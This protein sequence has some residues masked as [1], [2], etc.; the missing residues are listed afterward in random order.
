MNILK[1]LILAAAALSVAAFADAKDY[2]LTSPDGSIEMTVNTDGQMTIR[3]EHDGV[4]VLSPSPISIERMDGVTWGVNPRVQKAVKA[5]ADGIVK[6]QF[7]RAS[8]VKEKYNSLILKMRGGWSLELRAFDDGVAYRFVNNDKK[9]FEIRDEKADFRFP[10]DAETIVPYVANRKDGDF[11]GQYINSFENTYTVSH[12]S[13]LNQQHLSFLPLTV[14][15]GDDVK[16]CFT[17]VN[18]RDYPGMYLYNN[19]GSNHLV[20]HFAPYP[21]ETY[22][23]GHNNLQ[24]FVKDREEYI[25]KVSGPREFP[26]RAIVIGS[27]VELAASDMTYLLADGSK[28]EDTSW[29]RPGKV[30]WDWWNAWNIAGVDF[31]AGVNNDTYKHYIDFAAEK[32]IEYVILD[33][34]WAVKKQADLFQVVPAIDLPM[35][36]EYADSKGVGLI[37]WAGYIAF[38]RDMEKVCRHYSEMGIKGFKVDFMDRDDQLMTDFNYRAA[39]MAARYNLVLDLHGT[40]KPAGLNRTWPNVLNFE[41]VHGLEQMKWT[42]PSTDQMLYDVQLPFIRQVA[43]P[44]D[45]TQGAMLNATK[46]NFRP[47]HNEPMSQGTRCH[48]LALYMVLDS[49][50]NML[51]DSP[52][53]YLREPESTAFI[54]DVPTFWDET[55]V[56]SG[57]VGEYIATARRSGDIWYIG[58]ITNWDARTLEIDLSFLGEGSYTLDAFADGMNAHRK[59]SD[60]RRTSSEVTGATRLT[61]KLAPGGG[62]AACARP[63]K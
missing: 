4:E 6:A 15:G 45:Y 61:V 50:L 5:S 27:D 19:D 16:L 20:S 18:L 59:A 53:N 40:H 28:I 47:C 42:D 21:K 55:R 32:G 31:V 51:C 62:W 17:E 57:K 29:I 46:K 9:P 63:A 8:K 22:Q 35:L 12:L 48:Q 43:G 33:E 13:K 49:P 58:A 11:N 7:Y 37:L 36:V 41:G 30:A 24:I 2:R 44:M 3:I 14:G 26:W 54:A 10:A 38:D 34:G 60:Y 56:L 52:T 39:E 1:K 25:A 23:G